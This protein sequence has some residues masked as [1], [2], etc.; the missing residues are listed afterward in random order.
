MKAESSS[1]FNIRFFKHKRRFATLQIFERHR[2]LKYRSLEP[3]TQAAAIHFFF[4]KEMPAG[5]P[6]MAGC[7]LGPM[8]QCQVFLNLNLN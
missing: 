1:E 7:C 5:S 4:V 6:P 2:I 3:P 8:F